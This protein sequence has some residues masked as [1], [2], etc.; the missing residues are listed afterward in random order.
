MTDGP[1]MIKKILRAFGR[2]GE[3]LGVPDAGEGQLNEAIADVVQSH[4]TSARP[5]AVKKMLIEGFLDKELC[6]YIKGEGN[7]ALASGD[8][9]ALMAALKPKA[10]EASFS[11]RQSVLSECL[12][13]LG[14]ASHA[15]VMGDLPDYCASGIM[16]AAH[17]LTVAVSNCALGAEGLAAAD[18]AQN[19]RCKIPKSESDDSPVMLAFRQC[20]DAW[21]GPHILDLHF[22]RNGHRANNDRVF[23][24]TNLVLMKA[25]FT[26]TKQK[27]S[28][29]LTASVDQDV[30]RA[31]LLG[32]SP[33]APPT[34]KLLWAMNFYTIAQVAEAGRITTGQDEWRSFDTAGASRLSDYL[35]ETC[36]LWRGTKSMCSTTQLQAAFRQFRVLNHPESGLVDDAV[37]AKLIFSLGLFSDDAFVTISVGEKPYRL[38]DC[39]W[40]W[41]ASRAPD[42]KRKNLVFS[43]ATLADYCYCTVSKKVF[44]TCNKVS[45]T[46]RTNGDKVVVD[47][48][49]PKVLDDTDA[50]IK[51]Q[52]EKAARGEVSKYPDFF[53]C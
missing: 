48:W 1:D 43:E 2:L 27:L 3:P 33:G 4:Q 36:G 53:S 26:D 13:Q 46:Q 7:F 14:G 21:Q 5:D 38:R 20:Q 42:T 15:S 50:G 29:T 49:Y 41:A 51:V 31:D 44:G 24:K 18:S 37:V 23:S 47:G 40:M 34:D 35:L 30:F 39:A 22:G 9:P 6:K 16:T 17:L 19:S 10:Q 12:K 25:K 32:D 52:A 8:V 45:C 11:T 28:L